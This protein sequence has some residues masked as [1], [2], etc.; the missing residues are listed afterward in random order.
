MEVILMLKE[1][2]FIDTL[3]IIDVNDRGQ[4]FREK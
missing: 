1:K 2:D 4:S 3:E